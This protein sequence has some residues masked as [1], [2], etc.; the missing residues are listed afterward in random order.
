MKYQWKFNTPAIRAKI[1]READEICQRFVDR[2]ALYAFKNVIDET[3]NTPILI[4]N[5]F[6]LLETTVEIIKGLAILVNVINIV[7]T[8]AIGSSTGFGAQ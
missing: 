5:Q 7:P 1:K 3:N 6:G 2:S 8:G 4:D